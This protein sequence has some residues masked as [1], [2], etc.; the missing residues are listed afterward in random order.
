MLP[1]K[2]QVFIISLVRLE[3]AYFDYTLMPEE[4]RKK[5]KNREPG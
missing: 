5:S 4:V 2:R 3:G 1:S